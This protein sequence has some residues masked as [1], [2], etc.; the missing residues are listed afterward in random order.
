MSFLNKLFIPQQSTFTKR[1]DKSL[2]KAT[3]VEVVEKECYQWRSPVHQAEAILKVLEMRQAV[4][5]GLRNQAILIAQEVVVL[6]L[7]DF[8]EDIELD[9]TEL[10]LEPLT[11]NYDTGLYRIKGK[12]DLWM[13]HNLDSKSVR[14]P[15]E[16]LSALQLLKD[17]PQ[18]FIQ[19]VKILE[20][21]RG[22]VP[23][24]DYRFME[25]KS[26]NFLTITQIPDPLLIVRICGRW[27]SMLQ[28]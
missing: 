12:L 20:M 11:D 17:F 21:V 7:H 16:A 19:E 10:S 23:S 4:S 28:W 2:I 13:M 3:E 8:S 1:D 22:K 24:K 14:L 15:R 25:E 9:H 27:F 18:S 5:L 26:P 6:A